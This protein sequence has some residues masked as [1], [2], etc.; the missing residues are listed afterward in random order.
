[1]DI[2][3]Y[4]LK[5]AKCVLKFYDLLKPQETTRLCFSATYRSDTSVCVAPVKKSQ[6]FKQALLQT[7]N[8]YQIHRT[9][10]YTV[11]GIPVICLPY[12]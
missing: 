9:R 6:W 11:Q 5:T 4:E 10:Y 8:D 3:K 2:S 12:S 1:M 7:A